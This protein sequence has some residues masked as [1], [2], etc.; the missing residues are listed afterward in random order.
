MITSYFIE[1]SFASSGQAFVGKAPPQD[2]RSG[3]VD[4]TRE[5]IT[6]GILSRSPKIFTTRLKPDFICKVPKNVTANVFFIWSGLAL[7]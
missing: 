2:D 5:I 1:V 4:Q 6:V 7:L 3:M